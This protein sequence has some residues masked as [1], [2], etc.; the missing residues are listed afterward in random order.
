MTKTEVLSKLGMNDRQLAAEFDISTQ[1]VNAWGDGDIPE[2]RVLQ[3]E[4]K[5]PEKFATKEKVA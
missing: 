5:Y 2:L 3:L 4:K 1:A